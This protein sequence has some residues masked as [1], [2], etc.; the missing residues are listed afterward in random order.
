MIRRAL[1][2]TGPL[3]FTLAVDSQTQARLGIGVAAL[4]ASLGRTQVA[5]PAVV[6]P[7][8]DLASLR[9]SYIGAQAQLQKAR[10]GADVSRKEYASEEFV[11]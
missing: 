10:A 4:N 7:V 2:L 11:R 3:A 8:Q 6:L 1:R 9:N 5:V